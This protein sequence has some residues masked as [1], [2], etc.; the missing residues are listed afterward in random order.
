M[1]KIRI[2]FNEFDYQLYHDYCLRYYTILDT[3]RKRS[4]H[5]FLEL[6][7][8]DIFPVGEHDLREAEIF[9]SKKCAELVADY[10]PMRKNNASIDLPQFQVCKEM[11]FLF[12][13]FEKIYRLIEKKGITPNYL[14]VVATFSKIVEEEKNAYL[15]AINEHDRKKAESVAPGIADII[16]TRLG[17]DAGWESVLF[18]LTRIVRKFNL[19]SPHQ[20]IDQNCI[21]LI[22]PAVVSHF[23]ADIGYE[24]IQSTL[25]R[26]FK[27]R[28]LAVFESLLNNKPFLP[29]HDT[30]TEISDNLIFQM[31]TSISSGDI[32]QKYLETV[33]DPGLPEIV[34]L[35]A[36]IS[37]S[38]ISEAITPSGRIYAPYPMKIQ[39]NYVSRFDI[40]VGN[41]LKSSVVLPEKRVVPPYSVYRKPGITQYSVIFMGIIILILFAITIAATSGIWNPVKPVA[42]TSTELNSILSIVENLQR[43]S[44]VAAKNDQTLYLRSPP[45]QMNI[46]PQSQTT[47]KGLT[48]AD[49]NKHFFTIAFGPDNTKIKKRV[50][51]TNLVSMAISGNY[52][53]ND[54]ILLDQFRAQFNNHSSTDKFSSDI[55]FG[56][57]ASIVMVFAPQSTLENVDDLAGTVISKNPETGTIHYLHMTQTTQFV[58]KEVVFI[59]SDY[60]GDQRTHWILRGLLDDLGFTGETYD[61]PDSIFYAGSENT[62]QLSDIDWKAVQLMYGSK[63]T[64][65]LTS[66]RVKALLPG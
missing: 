24:D 13:D 31:L 30:D 48:S 4:M 25:E 29:D 37:Q 49:I 40:D 57:K 58:S 18:E 3:T 23:N 19:A 34:D 62:T 53:D 26:Y 55:K 8:K 52:Q 63:I 35:P 20:K 36:V 14:L 42:N 61:Y 41:A 39:E 65:G 6:F 2:Q 27:E 33:S 45:V 47:K 50:P 64:S 59:N 5:L 32:D 1:E 17:S 60:N 7:E 38:D 16:K 44:T 66:D 22:G 54:T 11:P 12:G 10:D 9:F 43:N 46:T 28:E 51:E 21:Y 56:D 15:S